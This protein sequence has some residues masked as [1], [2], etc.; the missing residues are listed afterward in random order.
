MGAGGAQLLRGG[1]MRAARIG[2]LGA[3]LT[4]LLAQRRE[5]GCAGFVL[6]LEPGAALVQLVDAAADGLQ[7]L[8]PL[9]DAEIR[10][11]PGP[12][13]PVGADP[14]A[15]RRDQRG[16]RRQLPAPRE[17]VVQVAGGVHTGQQ[18][19]SCGGCTYLRR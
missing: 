16:L 11:L 10:R 4:A 2:H 17:G 8:A 9:D 1:G 19:R 3:G 5:R 6:L 18:T 7:R 14:D 12:A 15:V 13:Q